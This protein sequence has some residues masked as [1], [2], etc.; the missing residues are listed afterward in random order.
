MEAYDPGT[1]TRYPSWEA[2]V[3]ATSN[4]WVAGAILNEGKTT[5]PWM[6]GPFADKQ[7]AEKARN[8]LRSLFK[9]T[10]EDHP[11]TTAKFFVRPLWKPSR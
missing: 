5:W 10:M 11:N 2:L 9:R 8:R 7:E 6:E 3:E 1:N 4:G